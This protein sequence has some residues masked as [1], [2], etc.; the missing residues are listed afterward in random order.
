MPQ[1]P[2]ERFHSD[3]VAADQWLQSM[4]G[5]PSQQLG[6]GQPQGY[7]QQQGYSQP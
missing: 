7:P 4:S 6:Y 5:Q 3:V 1:G 2:D